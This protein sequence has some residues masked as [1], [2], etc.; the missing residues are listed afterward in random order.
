[1]AQRGSGS[2]NEVLGLGEKQNN[3]WGARESLTCAEYLA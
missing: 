3:V 1:M 2:V